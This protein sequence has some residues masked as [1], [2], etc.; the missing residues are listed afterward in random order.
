MLAVAGLGA[1]PAPVAGA[2]E[3][4]LWATVNVCDT[5][6][7][8]NVVGVRASMPG[9]GARGETMHLR[10]RLQY[11]NPDGAWRWVGRAADS[12]F[13]S[14][15]SAR[16]VSRQVGRD[17]EVAPPRSGVYVM[18]GVVYAQ[19]R[20]GDAVVRRARRVT[21][22]GRGDTVGADPRGASAAT[23]TVR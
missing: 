14:L 6:D 17:F 22:G 20:R 7:R 9:G 15:G 23:C 8:P 21:V 1:V 19:W 5:V 11:R 3:P 13:I 12:G 4:T 2:A 18:R 16:V 10:I